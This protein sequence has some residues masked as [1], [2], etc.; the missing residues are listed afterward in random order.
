MSVQGQRRLPYFC[1]T[2]SLLKHTLHLR[3][4]KYE[5]FPVWHVFHIWDV[6]VL[7]ILCN[8]RYCHLSDLIMRGFGIVSHQPI[9]QHG[10]QL[11][12]QGFEM[13]IGFRAKYTVIQW[14]FK[15]T[16]VQYGIK[17]QTTAC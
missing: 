5:T 15:T 11:C 10:C 6:T 3:T 2:T 17:T 14:I 13:L 9:I 16:N 7:H 4:C 12:G 1:S 8:R